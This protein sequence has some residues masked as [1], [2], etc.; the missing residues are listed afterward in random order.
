MNYIHAVIGTTKPGTLDLT[1]ARKFIEDTGA[2]AG[3]VKL[4][5]ET[6][7]ATVPTRGVWNLMMECNAPVHIVK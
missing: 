6:T 5:E 7:K 4:V 2:T 1:A 3:L